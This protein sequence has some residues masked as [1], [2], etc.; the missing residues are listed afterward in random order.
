MRLL[1]KRTVNVEI[2][3]QRK[4]Q[5]DLG[6]SLAKKVDAVRQTLQEEET[7]LETFRSQTVKKLQDDID[8]KVAEKENLE[9]GNVRLREERLLAQAP[10]D[11]KEEWQKVRE[12]RTEMANW[13]ERLTLTSVELI[14]KEAETLEHAQI[15]ERLR[16]EI[17]E[18]AE[19]STRT[20]KEAEKRLAQADVA[21]DSAKKEADLLLAS[22]KQTE[23]HVKVR[24]EDAS[25]R[26]IYLT[27]REM[28][29]TEREADLVSRE[30]KLKSRQDLLVKA[31]NYLAKKK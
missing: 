11:L 21:L 22:A 7:R 12:D 17:E 19:L 9:R 25:L 5:V 23:A 1:D 2:A 30:K 27:Q 28:S 20:L 18:R 3:T 13:N 14:A 4:Q 10:I 8:S 16:K 6:V 24:E 31:Q 26:E 29:V 15:L